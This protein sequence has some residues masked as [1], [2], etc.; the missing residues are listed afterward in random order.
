MKLN[1]IKNTLY[2]QK[3]SL[4]FYRIEMVVLII[5][6]IFTITVLI[7]CNNLKPELISNFNINNTAFEVLVNDDYAYVVNNK[8]LEIIDVKDKKNPKYI[9]FINTPGDALAV[10]FK[11]NYAYIADNYK[12]VQ[13]ID[14][15][16]KKNPKNVKTINS[17]E[18]WDIFVEDNHL[19]IGGRRGIMEI[20][21]ISNKENPQ[22]LISFPVYEHIQKV[23]K[24]KN[25]LY[26]LNFGHGLSIF[27]ISDDYK[28]IT[29]LSRIKLPANSANFF[30]EDDYAYVANTKDGLQIIDIS[31]P[32]SIIDNEKPKIISNIN[33]STGWVNGIF[34]YG[35]NAYL[36]DGENKIFIIDI[37]NKEKPV[38]KN[39]VKIPDSFTNFVYVQNNYCYVTYLKK[40]QENV[41]N[42][43]E[44]NT[45][46]SGL[47]IINLNN[48]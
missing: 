25:Y 19:Y 18:I 8:G 28:I 47:A 3:K 12:G 48:N 46:S 31:K 39:Y 6:T 37:S 32:E 24:Y 26:S 41:K 21:D 27:K 1:S 15:S 16:D 33:I 40:N 7:S 34:I 13:I 10:F 45:F 14:V 22:E 43:E 2:K 36:T 4:C 35:N 30:I 44:K 17:S 42:S 9:S 11:D 5:F 20:Y 23:I 38:Y 29:P